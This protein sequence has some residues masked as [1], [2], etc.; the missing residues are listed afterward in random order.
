MADGA[1]APGDLLSLPAEAL[2][3]LARGF[4]FLRDLLQTRGRLWGTTRATLC[5]R[6]VGVCEALL[7]LPSVSSPA[8]RLGG[9]PLFGGHRSRDGLAQFMLHMEEV[10]RVMRPKVMLNIGQQARRFIARRL[11]DVTVETRSACS[12][13][14]CQVS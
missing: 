11:D 10:R 8:G 6:V 13:N 2:V 5:R 4:H 7:H 3:F 14:A 12:I 1:D 9:S